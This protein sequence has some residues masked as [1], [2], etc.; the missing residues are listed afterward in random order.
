MIS[1]GSMLNFLWL[2]LNWMQEQKLGKPPGADEVPA[3]GAGC[4]RQWSESRFHTRSG[5]C[6]YLSVLSLD[7]LSMLRRS[8]LL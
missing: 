5:H 4:C 1:E 8:S 6:L 3:I 7:A 2:I